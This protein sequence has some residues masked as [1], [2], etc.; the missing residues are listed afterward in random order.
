MKNIQKLKII[1]G[2]VSV[3]VAICTF[4]LPAI[5]H[6][7]DWFNA[8]FAASGIILVAVLIILGLRNSIMHYFLLTLTICCCVISL[9]NYNETK[10]QNNVDKIVSKVENL[11][12]K[13]KETK[14]LDTIKMW[15]DSINIYEKQLSAIT[16]RKDGK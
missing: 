10:S 5:F 9:C 13:S 1:L 14:N 7:K 4:R 16:K 6:Y 8:S 15:L 12:S 2:A 3:F 11:V